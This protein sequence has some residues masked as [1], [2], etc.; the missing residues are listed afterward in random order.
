MSQRHW[1]ALMWGVPYLSD[2]GHWAL[3]DVQWLRKVPE[4][5]SS[6]RRRVVEADNF[7][8]GLHLVD[9]KVDL[10]VAFLCCFSTIDGHWL[11][12]PASLLY[13]SAFLDSLFSSCFL[14]GWIWRH[15]FKCTF[16]A[17]WW[18]KWGLRY[19]EV[20]PQPWRIS[21]FLRSS[22]SFRHC[23]QAGESASGKMLMSV[24]S[25]LDQ[26]PHGVVCPVTSK[27]IPSSWQLVR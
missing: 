16:F 26:N 14:L 6:G 25:P 27:Q 20:P 7:A 11:H 12:F 15:Q 24:Q 2:G 9:F 18:I 17:K 22:M 13:P 4:N 19:F 21:R 23:A 3:R 8:P 5:V 10:L 1:S